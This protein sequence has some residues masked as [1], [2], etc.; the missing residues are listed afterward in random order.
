MYVFVSV[1][2]YA[3]LCVCIF[4]DESMA[5]IGEVCMYVCMYACM[6]AFLCECLYVRG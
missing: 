3:C 2:M 5:A 1:C 4:L 6:Y